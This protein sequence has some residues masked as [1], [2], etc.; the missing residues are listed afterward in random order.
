FSSKAVWESMR[1]YAPIVEW[2]NLIWHPSRI[3]KHAF[4]LWL[5]ILGVHW[6]GDKL[7]PL[8]IVPSAQCFFNCGDNE[9]VEHLFFA[10][11]YSQL[12][13]QKVLCMCNIH[14]QI[15]PWS[16]EI[17][18][19]VDHTRGNRFPHMIRKL[20]FGD[21]VY[22]LWM[23]RNQ[24]ALIVAFFPRSPSYS[25]FRE[26]LLLSWF[27]MCLL[28]L[29]QTITF[30]PWVAIGDCSTRMRSGNVSFLC[31]T[32]MLSYAGANLLRCLLSCYWDGSL[33]W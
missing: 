31:S 13:W 14:R 27:G 30:A 18:W 7:L 16:F 3:S 2:A 11:P 29:T 1:D 20:A 6:T 28:L 19:M 9:S 12:I 25:K 4:C 10:C 22:H 26:T 15:L 8:G 23:E 17:Q 32:S 21:I 24:E 33:L 5:A